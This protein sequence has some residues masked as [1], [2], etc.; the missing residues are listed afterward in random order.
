MK[1]SGVI[2]HGNDVIE[3]QFP[4]LSFFPRPRDPPLKNPML[5]EVPNSGHG[6]VS[7]VLHGL[8]VIGAHEHPPADDPTV[9]DLPLRDEPEEPVAVLHVV[10]V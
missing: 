1:G 4:Q 10:S 5:Q 9:E 8:V 6:E 7:L 3:R 2:V